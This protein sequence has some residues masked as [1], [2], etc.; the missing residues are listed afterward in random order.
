MTPSVASCAVHSYRVL[1]ALRRHVSIPWHAWRRQPSLSL[2]WLVATLTVTHA[3]APPATFTRFI[4]AYAIDVER[5]R[6]CRLVE[7]DD[8]VFYEFA[9]CI[10]YYLVPSPPLRWSPVITQTAC[11]TAWD[12]LGL[13]GTAW[14]HMGPVGPM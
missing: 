5:S 7:A 3:A 12:R 13:C 2:A 9:H 6:S 8:D 14:D 4:N 1:S 10:G 11:G